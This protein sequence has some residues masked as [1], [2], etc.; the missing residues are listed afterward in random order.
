M[1]Q[2]HNGTTIT[3]VQPGAGMAAGLDLPDYGYAIVGSVILAGDV[4]S[5]EAAI[6]GNGAGGLTTTP[7]YQAARAALPGDHIMFAWVDTASTLATA[8][9]PRA[10][11]TSPAW[12]GPPAGSTSS[13]CR[14]GRRRRSLPRTAGS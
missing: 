14:R 6:D 9:R 2:D 5:I 3:V 4:P 12:S 13:S 1:T 8:V 10:G 7:E 11:S